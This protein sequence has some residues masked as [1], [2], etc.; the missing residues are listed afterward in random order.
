MP[1]ERLPKYSSRFGRA[2]T[3]TF[4]NVTTSIAASVWRL[5]T[6]RPS[7]NG[8]RPSNASRHPILPFWTLYLFCY[9]INAT[10]PYLFAQCA[11]ILSIIST[12]H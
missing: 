7:R 3:S 2:K 4:E 1:T 9:S 6:D 5:G 12:R 10:K 11:K 8:E